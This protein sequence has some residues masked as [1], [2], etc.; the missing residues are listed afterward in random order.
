MAKIDPK[1]EL[2]AAI[3][4]NF[5]KFDGINKDGLYITIDGIQYNIKITAKKKPIQFEGMLKEIE[6]PT[7]EELIQQIKQLEVTPTQR[8]AIIK[9][10]GVVCLQ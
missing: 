5:D 9:K 1:V 3:Q 4:K 2:Y 7:K 8:A 10:G 6:Q